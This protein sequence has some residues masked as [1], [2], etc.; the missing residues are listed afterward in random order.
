MEVLGDPDN[1]ASSVSQG[2]HSLLALAILPPFYRLS[3]HDNY[4][5]HTITVWCSP[6]C[7]GEKML[8]QTGLEQMRQWIQIVF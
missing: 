5:Q 3:V 7:E 2:E 6:D 8:Q 1:V 4:T